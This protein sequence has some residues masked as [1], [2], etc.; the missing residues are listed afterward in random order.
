LFV[1]AY[2][3]YYGCEFGTLIDVLILMIIISQECT[4]FVCIHA[5]SKLQQ[6]LSRAKDAVRKFKQE[7]EKMTPTPDCMFLASLSV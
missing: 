6:Q 3:H 4:S 2:D 5:G 1:E 7:L